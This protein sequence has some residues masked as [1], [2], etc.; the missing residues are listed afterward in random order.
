[1]CIVVAWL[2]TSAADTSSHFAPATKIAVHCG[3]KLYGYACSSLLL[4]IS[5][6][7]RIA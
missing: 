5:G 2:A 6:R 7:G 3:S 4:C 1:M